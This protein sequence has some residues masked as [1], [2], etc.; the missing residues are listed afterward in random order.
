[1]KYAF[2]LAGVLCFCAGSAFAQPEF[3]Q[4]T[5]REELLARLA[6]EGVEPTGIQAG[7]TVTIRGTPFVV[8]LRAT[9]DTLCQSAI[10]EFRTQREELAAIESANGRAE[11]AETTAREER[12]RADTYASMFILF[13]TLAAGQ[14]P[15]VILFFVLVV[16]GL[17]ARRAQE[18][19]IASFA[20]RSK[21]L[22]RK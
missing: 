21:P 15:I 12:Q 7:S 20:K 16:K 11:E 19:T 22:I 13:L 17:L 9:P 6:Q 4:E 5:C 2:T 18:A 1:M 10:A 8:P 14:F 3:T